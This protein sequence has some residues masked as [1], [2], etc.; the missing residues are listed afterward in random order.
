MEQVLA[1]LSVI[2]Q[3]EGLLP[4]LAGSRKGG[5]APPRV[6]DGVSCSHQLQRCE[7]GTEL[8]D[9]RFEPRDHPGEQGAAARDKDGLAEALLDG[10]VLH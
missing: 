9:P 1:V 7:V 3:G 6:Q 8:S 2:R 10:L 4:K 5:S